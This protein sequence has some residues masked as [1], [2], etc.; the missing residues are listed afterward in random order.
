MKQ[1]YLQSRLKSKKLPIFQNSWEMFSVILLNI[2]CKNVCVRG[3][4]G[5]RLTLEVFSLLP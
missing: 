4:N 3:K 2:P 1:A 5:E